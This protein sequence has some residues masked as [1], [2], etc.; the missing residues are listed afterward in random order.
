V[1]LQF[2][3]LAGILQPMTAKGQQVTHGI[4]SWMENGR[5]TECNGRFSLKKT[6]DG[7]VKNII[8]STSYSLLVLLYF[9]E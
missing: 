7:K 2:E 3:D 9:G 8:R 6:N 4:A 1:V 5:F